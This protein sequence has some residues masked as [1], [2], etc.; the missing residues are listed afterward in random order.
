MNESDERPV[1]FERLNLLGKAAFF[2]GSAVRIAAGL[3]DT[4]IHHAAGI[5]VDAERAFKQGMDP[6]IEDAKVIGETEDRSDR[7][8]A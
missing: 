5:Y 6:N 2:G 1:E 8:N 4:A 7:F 3:I